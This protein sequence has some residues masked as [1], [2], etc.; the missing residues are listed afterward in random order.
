MFPNV[1][2]A[3]LAKDLKMEM[4]IKMEMKMKVT[5]LAFGAFPSNGHSVG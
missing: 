2:M 5:E 1:S 4:K 3:A